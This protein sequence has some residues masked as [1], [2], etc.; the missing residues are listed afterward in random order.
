MKMLKTI[1]RLLSEKLNRIAKD[2]RTA[3]PSASRAI[4]KPYLMGYILLTAHRAQIF[5][6]SAVLIL[7][8]VIAPL[9]DSS[10]RTVFP[11]KTSK[12]FLGLVKEKKQNIVQ[13][14]AYRR[15]LFLLWV[16]TA[17][18]TFLLVWLYIPKGTARALS[19][20]QKSENE[21]DSYLSDKPAESLTAYL[22]AVRLTSD[23][24]YEAHLHQKIQAF[25]SPGSATQLST[26]DS[27]DTFIGTSAH[28]LL[29]GS[30]SDTSRTAAGQSASIGPADRYTIGDELGRGGMGI[31]Y[32][33]HDNVLDRAVALKKLPRALTDDKEYLARFE[34]EAKTLARLTHPAI[35][36]IYDLLEDRDDVW[37]ALEYIDGGDLANYLSA[38]RPLSYSEAARIGSI[39]AEGMAYAHAQGT[40]HRDL[41]PANIL[42]DRSIRPKI[43]DF[44]L[45]KLSLSNSVTVEGSILGSP[46]YMSP[47]QAAGKDVDQRTDIYSLGI[48]LYEMV[49]GRTPFDGDT[50]Q[51]LSQH[52]T[53]PPPSLRTIVPD[54]P[55]ELEALIA[56][57]LTKEVDERIETM[58]EVVKTLDVWV[59]KPRAAYLMDS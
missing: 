8:L 52:I 55:E 4:R 54:L 14:R 44:G 51:I 11:E 45:A 34:R 5:L 1:S 30:E 42:L 46:R 9:L 29:S 16:C 25:L 31:V 43:S 21:G 20:A 33:A 17:S 23:P 38:H 57:M 27:A 28:N 18:E 56:Y 7:I 3:V 22:R 39:I 50:S 24:G 40:I 53:Q 6:A 58:N 35:L 12:R 32:K 19:R 2:V 36:Q 37:M 15:I 13:K 10:L 47:E 59:P 41:K 49:A 48:I 26:P